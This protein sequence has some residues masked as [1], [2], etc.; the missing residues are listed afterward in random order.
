[1]PVLDAKLEEI[2]L[3]RQ[4][5]DEEAD[6]TDFVDIMSDLQDDDLLAA[7][8]FLD[9]F[10]ADTGQEGELSQKTVSEL[11]SEDTES[12]F[13]LGIAY[14]EMGL[15]DD[16]IAEFDKASQDPARVVDCITLSGQ[17][18]LEAGNTDAAMEAF[19]AGLQQDGVTAEGLMTLN[20]ELGMVHQ[21]NG[22]LEEALECFQKV[23]EK[24]SFFRDV[25]DLIKNLR[26]ELNLNH[27]D[28]DDGPQGN[29][30]RVSYV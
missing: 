15:Y 29:R 13:N 3:A 30:D 6:T 16:A 28:D 4:S 25:G 12:H 1:M 11:D 20:F 9:S 19:R 24:D 10:G 2:N 27:S 22:Q 26:R 18:H 5:A 21:L 7:T 23:A 14:K 8:D 17:C